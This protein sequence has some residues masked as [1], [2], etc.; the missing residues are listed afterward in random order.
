MISVV[1]ITCLLLI[2]HVSY[3]KGAFTPTISAGNFCWKF[4]M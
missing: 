1:S 2:P 3:P 4:L